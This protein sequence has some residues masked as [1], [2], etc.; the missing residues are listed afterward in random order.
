MVGDYDWVRVIHLSSNLLTI[1]ILQLVAQVP[2]FW[3][4]AQNT[5]MSFQISPQVPLPR[6]CNSACLQFE[7]NT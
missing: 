2:A 3:C 1:G 6:P 4:N 7:H 5:I